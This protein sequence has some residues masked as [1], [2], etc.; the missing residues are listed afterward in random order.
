MNIYLPISTIWRTLMTQN[1]QQKNP[2]KEKAGKKYSVTIIE[3]RCKGCK[4]CVTYC[5]TGTLEMSKETNP[6][7]YYVPVIVDIS[8][9]KGC[10]LCSKYC[11][12]FAIFCSKT[13]GSKTSKMNK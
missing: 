6:K 9:C 13:L 5:P 4:L 8:T 1:K 3:D 10:N 7:G 12:D 2:V 11:P